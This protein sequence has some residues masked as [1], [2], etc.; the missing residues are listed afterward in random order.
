LEDIHP[1]FC[2]RDRGYGTL[3]GEL[4]PNIS[5]GKIMTD[6][7]LT[8][9]CHGVVLRKETIKD[10]KNPP[11]FRRQVEIKIRDPNSAFN[12][13]LIKGECEEDMKLLTSVVFNIVS[14]TKKNDDKKIE[15]TTEFPMAENIRSILHL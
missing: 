9:D 2:L 4:K 13:E 14:V 15:I 10:P 6:N 8:K 12:G 5:G 11:A 7:V 3:E 1:G